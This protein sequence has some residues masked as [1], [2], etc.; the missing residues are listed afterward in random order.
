MDKVVIGSIL[1]DEDEELFMVLAV[2]VQTL[3][4]SLQIK[5]LRHGYTFPGTEDDYELLC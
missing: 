3:P 4:P 1:R 2:D 5:S